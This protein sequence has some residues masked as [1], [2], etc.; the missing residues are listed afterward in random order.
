MGKQYISTVSASHAHSLDILAV[1]VTDKFTIT[2]SS[3]G[4]AAFWD[5]KQ[6]DVHDPH[7]HV[8]KHLISDMGIHHVAVFE[9]ILPGLTTKI[10]L[11]AFACFDSSVRMYYFTNDDIA[12][13]APVDTGKTFSDGFW[14]PGFFKCPL[15]KYDQLIL[16]KA[17]GNAS[18][19]ALN[20]IEDEATKAL[21]IQVTR[22][23]GDLTA[24]VNTTAFPNSLGI[25]PTVDPLVAVGYT[26]GDVVVYTLN[27]LK[28]LFTFHSTD[29]QLSSKTGSDSVPRVL[30]F[31]P[32]GTLIAVARDNQSA[33]SLTL[34]DVKY[35]ENV[36]SLTTMTHS[37]K[38]TVGG[39]A[40]E[41]WIMDL[42]FNEDG[43]M[44]ASCGFD[45][46]VRVWNVESREH[47]ATIHISVSDLENTEI[48]DDIDTSVCSGVAFIKRGV[49][50]G[51]GGDSNEGLCVVS[52]DRGVRW[53]R[54]AGGI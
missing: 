31:S 39:F 23:L 16:T 48:N 27:G 13:F 30:K 46:C 3:D 50:A 47:E 32:G 7:D 17:S 24:S 45:K 10:V 20:I 14:V 6:D 29:L 37:A 18:V 22:H 9:N 43:S 42:D 19:F 5:N 35:G 11:M 41:G 15:S 53:Y 38:T 26:S 36:G 21:D 51:A 25:S 54:E 1:A 52:F 33:G 8:T 49:R 28:A 12:T 4:Y 40:H 34:Y 44:L 2:V